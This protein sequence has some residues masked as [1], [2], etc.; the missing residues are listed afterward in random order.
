MGGSCTLGANLQGGC[1]ITH[2]AQWVLRLL[3]DV[4][5]NAT[6]D[7]SGVNPTE[8]HGNKSALRLADPFTMQDIFPCRQRS[9]SMGGQLNTSSDCSD[10]ATR[11]HSSRFHAVV[12]R[13][14]WTTSHNQHTMETHD[15]VR[16]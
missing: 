7:A 3:S 6:H 16:D 10:A 4:N 1:S 14:L 13:E 12:I 9:G 15:H 5:S 2:P 8:V 11:G